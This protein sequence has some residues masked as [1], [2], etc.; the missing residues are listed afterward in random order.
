MAWAICLLPVVPRVGLAASSSGEPWQSLPP[1]PSLPHAVKSGAAPV[2]G[3]RMFYA[4]FGHGP[5][6]LLLHGGLGN[7]NYWG[8]VIPILVGGGFEVIV[9]DSRGHGRSTRTAE[10]YS[11]ELMASDVLALLD[12]LKLQKVD[13]VGWSDGGIIG[14]VIAMNH[15]ERL[16]RLFAY[17][18]NGDPSGVKPDLES[19]PTFASYLERAQREYRELS[20]TPG[21]YDAFLAQIQAMWAQQPNFTAAQ[22]QRIKTPTAI[23]DGAHEEAIKREHTEHLAKTIPGAKLIILPDVSHFGMV[24]NPKE[25]GATVIEFLK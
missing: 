23:A 10:P 7:S 8:D 17:G 4:V 6:V 24:Q 9:A 25:L 2:N 19:N 3:I 20:P 22:L 15:P 1:T 12:Y 18:A 14:F 11:Y 21:D 13:I 5:P 16:R